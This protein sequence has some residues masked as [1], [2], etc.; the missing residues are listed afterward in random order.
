MNYRNLVAVGIDINTID[1]LFDFID[2]HI[3][4]S[5]PDLVASLRTTYRLTPNQAG[6]AWV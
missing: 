6:Q 4:D 1:E 2:T 3:K 5:L